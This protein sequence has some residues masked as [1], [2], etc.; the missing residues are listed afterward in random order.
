MNKPTLSPTSPS[1]DGATWS[2]EITGIYGT[3]MAI[4]P[5]KY[6]ANSYINDSNIRLADWASDDR[7]TLLVSRVLPLTSAALG[8][9][10]R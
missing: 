5:Y 10:L 4:S 6:C 1:P 3:K 7:D 8:G 2:P 9:L